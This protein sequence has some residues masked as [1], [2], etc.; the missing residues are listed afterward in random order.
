MSRT[1]RYK[2]QGTLG[3][4]FMAAGMFLLTLL[5][6]NST[7]FE[8]SA[9]TVVFGLGLGISMSVFNVV[10]QNAVEA[11]YM[12]SSISAI[13]FIRQM[14]GTIGLA[15][16]GSLVNQKL[17]QQIPKHV[18]GQVLAGIP[19]QL[20][21]QLLNPE[22]LFGGG[23]SKVLASAPPA[24]RAQLARALPTIIEGVRV[25]LAESVHVAFVIGLVLAL[26]AAG[27]SLF[28]REIPLKRMTAAQERAMAA[29]SESPAA[30]A[31]V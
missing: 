29:R 19:A 9:F 24:A 1:G 25:S 12:S 13:Q 20:R 28:I 7:Q 6:A 31:S 4:V 14:G 27:I 2:I 17:V 16:I 10:S 26:L 30:T 22:A 18:P 21:S 23:I 11:R 5:D 15:I 3:F 8:V